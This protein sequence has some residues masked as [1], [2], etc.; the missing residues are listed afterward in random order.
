MNP[1]ELIASWTDIRLESELE[2]AMTAME[3]PQ[4]SPECRDS[5]CAAAALMAIELAKRKEGK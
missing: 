5:A 1:L 3:D 4:H 2:Q